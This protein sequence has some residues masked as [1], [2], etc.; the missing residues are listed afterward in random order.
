MDHLNTKLVQYSD[1]D[2]SE[3]YEMQSKSEYQNQNTRPFDE[4]D[5]FVT[6][7]K[8]VWYSNVQFYTCFQF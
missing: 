4:L 2:C 1:V 5:Y 3:N 8:M 7:N 6:R